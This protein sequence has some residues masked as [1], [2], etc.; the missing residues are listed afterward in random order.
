MRFLGIGSS[1]DASPQS[2]A[3]AS[4]SAP[5]FSSSTAVASGPARPIRLVYCDEK[6]KFQMDP[7]AV[8]VLQLVKEP[9]GVVSVC[10]RAR[11]GKSFILN[12]L[13]GRSNGFQ[14][15][16]T[17]RPCTKGLWLWST[18]IKKT[19]LDGT[20][21]NLLLL[22]S[23]GIDAYDQTGTYSTQIF[24]LAVLLSSMFI[25]NQMGGIDE[26]A[27]DRLSLVTEMTKHIRV[28]ASGGKTTASELGQFSPIFVWLL[29]DFYLDL[30][31]DN[32]K[33][34]P[35]DYLELA[36][37]PVNGGVRDVAAKNEIRESIRALFPDRDCFTLVRPLNNENELQRLDQ[38]PL[39]KMRP[40]FKSGL[41]ALTRFVFE[42]TRPKQVGATVMTGPIFARI[43]QSFLDALN[44][45]AVPTITSSWQSVEEAECERAYDSATELY[46]S[47]FDR[48]KPPEEAAMREAHEEAVQKAVATFNAIAVGT[49]S[50]RQ[51]YEKRFHTF[52]RKA[53]EDYKRNAFREAYLQCSNA[54]QNMEK[55]LRK[56][57]Q[58]PSTKL[59]DVLKVLDRLLSKYEATTHGPEKWQKLTSFLR[60]S[61]EGPILDL[62]KKQIDHIVSEKSSLQLKCRSIEDKMELLSKQ[63]EASEKYKSDYLKRYE[64]AINDKNK[65]SQDYMSR[66]TNLQKN[67]SSLDE[68]CSGLSRTLEAA[69]QESTEWKRK[70]ELSL[71]KQKALEDQAGSEVANLK[72]RNSAAEARLAAAQ[73]QTMSAQEEAQEWK[74]KYDIAVREAKSALEKAAAV[75]DRSSKQTQHREDTLRAEFAG[76]LAEKE[77]ELKDRASKLEYAEQCVTTLSLQ[78]KTAESKITNYDSEVSYLKS[79]IKELGE[80]LESANAT[81][82]S[83]E[84]EAKILEQEKVHLEQKYRSEFDRFEEVQERCRNAEKETKRATELAD[85]ARAEAV[86]AQKEKSE[87]Q[88]LAGE[89]L[90]E[91]ARSERRIENLERQTK[92][93]ANELDRFRAAEMDAVSKVTMLEARVGERE[94]EIETL[95]KSN[96]EQR[97]STVHVLEGLL[98]TERIARAEANNR[99]E[100]L[101]VQLQATQGKLD[102]LQQQMTTVRLNESALDGKLKTASHGKRVRVEDTMGTDSVQEMDVEN[103]RRASKRSRSTT[104]PQD[105]GSLFKGD[106]D[107]QS[108]Q[109]SSEDHTKFTILKLKQ[110]LTKHNFGA[111]LLQLKNPNKKE[112]VALYERCILEKP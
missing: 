37:R 61:L 23:E 66:I 27:L 45:G 20:E 35:R 99:A 7:E 10:G 64:D 22:D 43:T 2:T 78:L 15:A 51:K 31:E 11:Q 19:A 85:T 107:N 32:R 50:A 36:L 108:Q 84:R 104:S 94:K 29:R 53:F 92:D 65:L 71:S 98:E 13:L 59:D 67:S 100:A 24:S 30:A 58:A 34:T 81:A 95:L 76:T 103:R 21:Y 41:D 90:T 46:V 4:S 112:L 80:R 109:T 97:A 14:V 74:R 33:I 89:R 18:P 12:Q 39:E 52:L 5:N 55:E 75:Q 101:S 106:E 42:R 54:I 16:S 47:I 38:I 102:L 6:G 9:V 73:E 63:L 96:N 79:Q 8:S 28:R 44:N 1:D 68:R 48:T 17:H 105:G 111:E 87:I 83:Y 82:Q 49:G 69:K 110:E 77:A 25:Y 60:Q 57:C 40:E 3:T 56:T 86:T 91:I 88:R 93:L 26:A 70:Y 72:A 62:V